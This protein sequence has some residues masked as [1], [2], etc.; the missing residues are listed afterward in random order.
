MLSLMN[1][2]SRGSGCWWEAFK[3]KKPPIRSHCGGQDFFLFVNRSRWYRLRVHVGQRSVKRCDF[4]GF[5]GR[6]CIMRISGYLEDHPRY[7]K[8]GG[9]FKCFLFSSL[10][11]EMIQFD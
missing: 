5:T 1:R 4:G 11:G 6:E 9:G 3:K 8:L 7:P 10:P 2:S